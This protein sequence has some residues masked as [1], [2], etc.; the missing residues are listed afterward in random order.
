MNKEKVSVTGYGNAELYAIIWRPDDHPKAILQVTHGMTE[1]IGRYALL[2]EQLTAQGIVVAG[3][4]LRGHGMNAQDLK[5]ASFGENGW[6]ASLEDMHLLY[7]YLQQR[8]PCCPHFMLGFSLGSFLLREYMNYYHEP[9]SGVILSGTGYQ[10]GIVLSI[11]M[12]LVKTQIKKVGFDQTT[13]LVQKLSFG[14]YNQKFVPNR[15]SADWLCADEKELND[16]LE[17]PLCREQ[18]SAGLFWQL[19]GSMKKTGRWSSYDTWDKNTPVLL[20]SGQNDPVGDNGKAVVKI[21]KMMSRVRIKNVTMHL[22]PGARH[23]VLHE[24]SCGC[25]KQVRNILQDWILEIISK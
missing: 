22:F 10:P 15:T 19:L 7:H 25:A 9:I 12:A 11:I 17:D 24:E 2:A 13:T 1:H 23:D 20:L 8:F 21:K 3:F 6:D 14:I 5:C 4:D 18:I 16:Y